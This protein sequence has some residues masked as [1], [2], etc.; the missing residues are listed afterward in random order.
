MLFVQVNSSDYADSRITMP[1]KTNNINI[2]KT[3]G[4]CNP[5]I[6]EGTV[7]IDALRDFQIKSMNYRK[8]WSF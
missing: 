8:I 3:K 1:A 7:D 6:L 2:I 4:G 5:A